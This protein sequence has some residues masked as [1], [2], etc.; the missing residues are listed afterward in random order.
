VSLII[1]TYRKLR[2]E[3]DGKFSSHFVGL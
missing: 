2:V 1:F 3:K